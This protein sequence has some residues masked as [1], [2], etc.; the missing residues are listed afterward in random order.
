MLQKNKDLSHLT[1]FAVGAVA[2]QFVEINSEEHLLELIKTHDIDLDKTYILGGGS[3]TLLTS[4][5]DGLV[6]HNNIKGIEVISEDELAVRVKVGAGEDWH[7]F[8]MY[9]LEH[10][11]YGM[12]NLALIPGS[13][14]ASP[15]Q[16]IGAYGVEV[17]SFI[18]H[19]NGIWLS[20]GE[21]AMYSK[22]QCELKYRDSIFKKELK[23]KFFITSVEFYLSKTEDLILEYEGIVHELEES[24][25]DASKWTARDLADAVISIRRRKL[26]DP[27]KIGTAGSFFKNPIIEE[28]KFISLIESYP[29][30]PSYDVPFNDG[31]KKQVKLPAGWL[32][33]QAG[34]KGWTSEDGK[35]GVHKNHALVLVN[36]SDAKGEE[37]W[38]LANEIMNSVEKKFG[39]RLEPEVNILP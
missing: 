10:G 36:Y 9:A 21:T 28:E 24:G 30:I 1:T 23:N 19:V 31:V 18:K 13:V 17:D 22:E 3:N 11:W 4:D 39:I 8:V 16:N 2:K 12:E 33:E 14:G 20:S 5:I 26:P 6:I 25:K 32:C 34:W 29:D 38:S 35:Y 15:V 37:I 27:K 7:Q